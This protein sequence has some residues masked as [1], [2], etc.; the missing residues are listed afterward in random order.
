MTVTD[1]RL[2]GGVEAAGLTAAADERSFAMPSASSFSSGPAQAG[3]VLLAGELGLSWSFDIAAGL[4]RSY[5]T[6]ITGKFSIVP[7]TAEATP[8]VACA[9]TGKDGVAVRAC[10]V[11]PGAGVGVSIF[12]ASAAEPEEG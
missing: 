7:L 2:C 12:A 9:L 5:P 8:E 3:V 4:I 11:R 6:G 10:I 1:L